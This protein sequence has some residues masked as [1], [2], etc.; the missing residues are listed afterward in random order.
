MLKDIRLRRP[1]NFQR[2]LAVEESEAA[3]DLLRKAESWEQK[4]NETRSL[5]PDI[6]DQLGE[7]NTKLT[8]FQEALHQVIDDIRKTATTNNESIAKL[9]VHEK[10]QEILEEDIDTLNNTLGMATDILDVSHGIIFEVNEAIQNASR[11]YAEIDGAKVQLQD[12]Q[13]N[14][15]R[16]DEDLVEK[17]MKYAQGLQDL[18]DNLERTFH[19]IDTN[20]LVQKALNASNVHENIINYINEA[21]QMSVLAL[22][23]TERVSDAAVGID[24]QITYHKDK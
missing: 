17:A 19:G 4:H 8:D 7:H 6:L 2:Q 21:N 9:Q 24:T 3:Q 14:Q 10:Q 13:A 11:F 18:A 15:S 5:I 23:T 16:F 12:K 20:G 22:N 1:F